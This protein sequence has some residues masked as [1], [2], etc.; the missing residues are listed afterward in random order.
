LFQTNMT[1]TFRQLLILS[2]FALLPLP[3]RAECRRT[4][5]AAD[6]QLCRNLQYILYAA[7]T[8]FRE[9]SGT[10]KA[11][12]DLSF[13][14]AKVPCQ[15]SAWANN[16]PMMMC[17]GQVFYPDAQAWYSKTIT[18]LQQL[19]YLWHFKIDSPNSDHYV[20]GGP[21]DCEVPPSDGPYVGQC[22]LHVQSVKQPDGSAKIYLWVNSY[23]SPYLVPKPPPPPSK[24]PKPGNPDTAQ[25]AASVLVCD[26]LCS[27]LKQIIEAR[28]TA[29]SQLRPASPLAGGT[30]SASTAG[31]PPEAS[32]SGAVPAASDA[33]TPA[34]PAPS[35]VDFLLKLL[36]TSNCS[37]DTPPAALTPAP[38]AAASANAAALPVSPAQY[39]CYWSESSSSAAEARFHDI[40]TRVQLVMPSGWTAKKEDSFEPLTGA[41]LTSWFALDPSSKPIVRLYVS[42][43][44]VGLHVS[45]Q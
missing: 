30:G 12:P 3:A 15:L 2:C 5:V 32:T 25:P 37:I 41:K 18:A 26:D 8:D 13:G 24:A 23:T 21:P 6:D 16:V 43:Q 9:F 31:D 17:Y 36:G 20:D 38:S 10:G 4:G 35:P 29:F 39:A 27:G 22:P 40:S 42:A 33:A 45:A 19:Q 44:S 28:T 14:S 11:T 1:R 34:A 7:Q